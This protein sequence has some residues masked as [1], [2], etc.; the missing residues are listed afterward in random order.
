VSTWQPATGRQLWALNERG[1]LSLA[2]SRSGGQTVDKATAWTLLAD[3]YRLSGECPGKCEWPLSC[4]RDG[5]WLA[6]HAAYIGTNGSG[7]GAE[8]D[9]ALVYHRKVWANN[10]SRVL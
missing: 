2:L 8:L 10:R 4:A 5:C 6:E 1:L 7:D 3:W 9:P